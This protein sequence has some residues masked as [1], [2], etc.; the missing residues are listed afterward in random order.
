MKLDPESLKR[1]YPAISPEFESRMRVMIHRL[2]SQK[3]EPPMKRTALKTVLVFSLITI[4]LC[5]TAFALL[6]GGLEWYY[7][8]RFTA[9][10]TYEPEK[11]AA[12]LQNLQTDIPQTASA[13]Q[14]IRIGVQ[15][16]AWVEEQNFLAVSFAAAPLSPDTTELH[17]MWNLDAD[18]SYVGPEGDPSPESDG[19][20]RAI[21]WLWVNG[22]F[23]PV[24]EMIAPGKQLLLL[25]LD[26]LY[27]NGD[28]LSD[29][30]TSMDAFRDEA[31]NVY[32]VLEAQLDFMRADYEEEMRQRMETHPEWKA[33]YQ[34]QLEKG[35][36]LRSIIENA[37]DGMVNVTA[38]YTL[39][40]YSADDAL[41]YQGG[42][43]GEISFQLQVK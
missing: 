43:T 14:Q 31:G 38:V 40:P 17:P 22:A 2:S 23:G 34:A 10:Q 7:N 1:G 21:H 16:A 24:E 26:Q 32:T 3:E 13:Q 4:L 11:Y 28:Q 5:S 33:D 41:L 25:E 39:T 18:G 35:L 12:I 37:P 27:L 9:Y 36:R 20:D 29:L 42:Q 19:E 8:T 30:A 15:D 6:S